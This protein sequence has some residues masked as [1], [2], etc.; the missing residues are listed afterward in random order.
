MSSL[1]KASAPNYS[2]SNKPNDITIDATLSE[3][4]SFNQH[5]TFVKNQNEQEDY[6]TIIEY[7]SSD[8]KDIRRE[9]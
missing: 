8:I 1:T 5:G 7:I 9:C 3:Q 4:A 2:H 6:P